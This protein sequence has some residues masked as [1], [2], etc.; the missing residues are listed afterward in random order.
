MKISIEVRYSGEEVEAIV[1]AAHVARFG[2][3]PEGMAWNVNSTYS[4]RV[5][6]TAVEIKETEAASE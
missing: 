2:A 4:G 5:E 6:V 3:P 1:M